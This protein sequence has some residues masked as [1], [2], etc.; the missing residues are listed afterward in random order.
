[1]ALQT[2]P[3][4]PAPLREVVRG[5]QGWVDRLGSVWIEAQV[6]E[7]KSYPSVTF[8]TLRDPLAEVSVTATVDSVVLNGAGPVQPSAQVVAELKPYVHTKATSLRFACTDLRP[9]GQGR[10]LARLEQLR[11]RLAAEGLFDRERKRPLPFLPRSIGLI[12]AGGSAAE[13]DVLENSRRR[14]PAATFTVRN[15]PVQGQQAG[16]E[17]ITAIGHLDRDPSVEVIVIARGGGSL[18]DLLAF[19]DEGVVRAAAAARTPIVSAIGHETDTPLLDHVADLRASTPTDAARHIL[20]D[21]RE[22]ARG[23]QQARQRLD[24]AIGNL[25]GAEQQRLDQLRHRPGLANPLYGFELRHDQITA[26]RDR[27][28]RSVQNR[29]QAEGSEIQQALARVRAM[30][31]KATLDRGYAIVADAD[32]ATVSSVDQVSP[33]QAL[34]LR[35]ADGDLWVAVDE[36]IPRSTEPEGEQP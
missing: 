2:S 33:D 5:V 19:S 32:G 16:L 13:R 35:L 27:A 12:T 23:V 25:L 29:L 3:D 36:V 15:V 11:Q 7:L 21:A 30:S 8:L 31:P 26:L 1:M 4:S 34:T 22:E 6:V 14:W 28:R 9:S 24:R 18:E 17:I 20:P 10:L